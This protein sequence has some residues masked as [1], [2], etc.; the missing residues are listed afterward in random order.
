MYNPTDRSQPLE[1]VEIPTRHPA[2]TLSERTIDT[3]SDGLDSPVQSRQG[4]SLRSNYPLEV[5]DDARKEVEVNSYSYSAKDLIQSEEETGD[6][7]ASALEGE[8]KKKKNKRL[9]T[10]V[11][12]PKEQRMPKSILRKPAEKFPEYPNEVREGVAPLLKAKTL[13][14][15]S[16]HLTARWTKINRSMVSPE[17]LK[18]TGERFEEFQD[19]VIVLRVLTKQE[20]QKL[21]N[22]T[23]EMPSKCTHPL[24]DE[25]KHANVHYNTRKGSHQASLSFTNQHLTYVPGVSSWGI[26]VGIPP[27]EDFKA[28]NDLEP[29]FSRVDLNSSHSSND[30]RTDRPF[31][32]T[33][34]QDTLTIYWNLERVIA[35]L[36]AHGFSSELEETF[37]RL[38]LHGSTFLALGKTNASK[39]PSLMYTTIHPK[40]AEITVEHGH[41]FD[42]TKAREEGKRLRKLVRSIVEEATASHM[43]GHGRDADWSQGWSEPTIQT[44]IPFTP[45]A[46]KGFT[47]F[48]GSLAS[49]EIPSY[50]KNDHFDSGSHAQPS[51]QNPTFNAT[52]TPLPPPLYHSQE[53]NFSFSSDSPSIKTR[54]S[55]VQN[56]IRR[57]V[58]LHHMR[59]QDP[60]LKEE[61]QRKARE[62]SAA[63]AASRR[64]QSAIMSRKGDETGK[65]TSASG[66]SRLRHV[67]SKNS[68]ASSK[69]GLIL[70]P[71]NPVSIRPES[72]HV[73]SDSLVPSSPYAGDAAASSSTAKEKA[74]DH[75]TKVETSIERR[76]RGKDPWEDNRGFA[77]IIKNVKGTRVSY[78]SPDT[79]EVS[80]HEGI[81]SESFEPRNIIFK[82]LSA[83]AATGTR[84]SEKD[85]R[86]QRDEDEE[87]RGRSTV[88]RSWRSRSRSR[89][90]GRQIRSSERIAQRRR[91]SGRNYIS[92]TAVGMVERMRSKSRDKRSRSRV[93]Q[94]LPIDAAGVGAAALAGIRQRPRSWSIES[95]EYTRLVPTVSKP[96]TEVSARGF[97]MRA[98]NDHADIQPQ[99][100]RAR[101][102]TESKTI[103]TSTT[104]APEA[105]YIS[106]PIN[107]VEGNQE[108]YRLPTPL[109]LPKNKQERFKQSVSSIGKHDTFPTPSRPPPIQIPSHA[110]TTQVVSSDEQ[111]S[112]NEVAY[113]PVDY[114]PQSPHYEP[115]S[116][117]ASKN[118]NIYKNLSLEAT[119]TDD[120]LKNTSAPQTDFDALLDR[121]VTGLSARWNS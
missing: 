65:K 91:S 120:G 105:D 49:S 62:G 108:I 103:S 109:V 110:S 7:Q 3:V 85:S 31:A 60:E 54:D 64:E 74:L 77:S 12:P 69:D 28:N 52:I 71:P 14:D 34:G 84:N 39:G 94:G 23:K 82:G 87:I 121:L 1:P 11:D 63:R 99:S 8:K 56:K 102:T 80:P 76:D 38:D 45:P 59:T 35:F 37:R 4:K 96:D 86:G 73:S 33:E 107:Q 9:S 117:S 104:I 44:K 68:S 95:D 47:A 27:L 111:E 97:G 79:A 118:E 6:G 50:K 19:H 13:R 101:P 115:S 67:S 98:P 114:T 22:R 17:A 92:I 66:G 43:L 15:Q 55:S 78:A 48:S 40:W 100:S 42:T 93:R 83:V 58:R 119:Q 116:P 36:Q 29:A 46:E 72:Q 25:L 26:G 5:D 75:P 10:V 32:S 30:A 112:N 16:T 18:E 2:R 61:R 81:P 70:K 113:S 90:H 89:S 51:P 20:V 41:T 106:P 21:A 57:D 24:H 88:R 53:S